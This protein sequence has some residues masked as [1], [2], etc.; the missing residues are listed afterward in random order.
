MSKSI[1]ERKYK[2]QNTAEYTILI[3]L[4][5]KIQDTK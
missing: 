1:H 4:S 2:E 5:L 3:P